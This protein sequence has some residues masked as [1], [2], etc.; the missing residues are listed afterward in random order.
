M[1][2]KINLL[3]LNINFNIKFIFNNISKIWKY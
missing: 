1:K 2:L 3:E